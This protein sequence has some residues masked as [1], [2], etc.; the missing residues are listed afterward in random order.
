MK[1]IISIIIFCLI[2]L[3]CKGEV[4]TS[5]NFTI[6][7]SKQYSWLVKHGDLK[8]WLKDSNL[9]FEV[10][11]KGEVSCFLTIQDALDVYSILQQFGQKLFDESDPSVKYETKVIQ[12]TDYAY[13]WTIGKHKLRIFLNNES[14]FLQVSYSG[15]QAI[16]LDVGLISEIAQVIGIILNN[17][18]AKQS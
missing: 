13:S 9:M 17:A 5:E 18:S 14:E 4:V 16:P 15:D 12:E 3:N 11:S 2:A 7:P 1:R 10:D 6:D 8:F